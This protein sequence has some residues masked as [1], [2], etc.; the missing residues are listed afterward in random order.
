MPLRRV[1]Q[2]YVI[3]T[4]T[5]V[6]L[7]SGIADKITDSDFARAK[8]QRTKKSED[9]FVEESEGYK[10]TAERKSVQSQIDSSLPKLS[11]TMRAYLRSKFSLQKGQYPH[12]MKF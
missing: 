4:E 12:A 11:P 7:P 5:K 10:V 9:G 6:Q 8:R 3:A 1:N 2:A